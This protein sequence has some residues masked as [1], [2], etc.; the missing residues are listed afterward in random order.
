AGA[1]YVFTRTAGVWTQQAYVKASNSEA[2]DFF[3]DSVALSGD[4]LAV[5]ATGEASCADG[6]G[7]DQAYNGCIR[8]GAVYVYGPQP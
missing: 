2:D 6:I 1:V 3:G 5:G 8:A 7:G 4:T